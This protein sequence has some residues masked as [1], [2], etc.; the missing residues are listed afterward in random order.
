MWD[1]IIN[2]LFGGTASGAM[3]ALVAIGFSLVYG[4]GGVLNLSHGG[5]F[6]L[7][8]YLIY[9]TLPL[10]DN[11]V[12]LSICISLVLITIIGGL[13]YILLIKPL[14]DSELSVVLVTFALAFFFEHFIRVTW[15]SKYETIRELVIFPGSTNFFGVALINQLI[16]L[17]LA[18]LAIVLIFMVSINKLKI[19]KSIRAVSQD[20]EAAMLMGI[21]ANR[22]LMYTVMISAFLAGLAAILFLPT[23]TL[24]PVGGWGVLTNAFAVVILGGMGSLLGSIVGAFILGYANSFTSVFIPNGPSWSHLVPI[25]LIVIMLIIRPQGLLGKKEID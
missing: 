13:A 22:I 24:S 8:G 2:M 3:Y 17:I 25:I 21:N 16:F 19:G 1:Q 4:V 5:F 20:R 10:F 18:A 14:Q 12:W 11:V 9:W 6:I 15:G 23:Q 7:T